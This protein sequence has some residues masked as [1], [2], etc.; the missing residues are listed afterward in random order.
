[1]ID[2]LPD[3]L[4]Q[5][6]VKTMLQLA[7]D[8]TELRIVDDQHGCPTAAQDIAEAIVQIVEPLLNGK[9]DGYGT[10]HFTNLGTTT[11]Y[12]FAREIFRQG[13]LRGLVFSTRLSPIS[14]A[15]RESAACRPL[16]SVLDTTRIERVY[17]IRARSWELALS[18]TL[19]TLLGGATAHLEGARAPRSR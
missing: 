12:R 15:E 10:F 16:N 9:S 19:V 17:G 18:E 11:W 4:K 6:F 13:E 3:E 2:T 7:R 1:V 8:R 14:S 5:N